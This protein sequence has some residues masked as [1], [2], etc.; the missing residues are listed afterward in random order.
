MQCL[1][2]GIDISLHAGLFSCFC[3]RLL[4]FFKI[5]FFK[6][7]FQVYTFRVSNGLNPDQA[8]RL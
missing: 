5:D 7:F 2:N 8:L 6:K 4:T 1:K 3:C